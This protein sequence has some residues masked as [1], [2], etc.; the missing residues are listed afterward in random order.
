MALTGVKPG[1]LP[2]HSLSLF[3]TEVFTIA[4]GSPGHSPQLEMSHAISDT[5]SADPRSPV[6]ALRGR[7]GHEY[8]LIQAADLSHSHGSMWHL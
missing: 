4:W 1:P 7:T 5:C 6:P 3:L 2:C 8:F